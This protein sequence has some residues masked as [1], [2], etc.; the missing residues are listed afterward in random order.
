[1]RGRELVF[2][3]ADMQLA[4][5]ALPAD[6]RPLFEVLLGLSHIL[7]RGLVRCGR[8]LIRVVVVDAR[9]DA[10]LFGQTGETV[11]VKARRSTRMFPAVA[12]EFLVWRVWDLLCHGA[13]KVRAGVPAPPAGPFRCYSRPG[14]GPGVPRPPAGPFRCSPRPGA[15]RGAA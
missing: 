8:H 12:V 5:A 6:L 4:I 15:G 2:L 9:F 11:I 3:A 13:S 10:F 1:M 7:G 14:A